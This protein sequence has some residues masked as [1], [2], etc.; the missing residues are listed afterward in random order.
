VIEGGIKGARESQGLYVDIVRELW[1]KAQFKRACRF[2]QYLEYKAVDL[3][4]LTSLFEMLIASCSPLGKDS[5]SPLI[6]QAKAREIKTDKLAASFA[7]KEH[8][9]E[10]WKRKSK[11]EM[12]ERDDE[13]ESE[14]LEEGVEGIVFG[15][16]ESLI[17][18]G[19]NSGER[20]D[21]SLLRHYLQLQDAHIAKKCKRD[22]LS[23]LLPFAALRV[24]PFPCPYSAFYTHTYSRMW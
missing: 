19:N 2:V 6:E 14:G 3:S 16:Y 10:S 20:E 11:D 9:K 8:A 4:A 15:I 12:E 17:A 21:F 1:E 24:C 7:N 13:A 23:Q 22:A 18:A 5:I